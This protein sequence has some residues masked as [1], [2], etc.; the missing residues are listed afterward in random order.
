MDIFYL[1]DSISLFGKFIKPRK[2][3][4]S[5]MTST[6]RY[7]L[8]VFVFLVAVE[9]HSDST[10]VDSIPIDPS[11]RF[12][13]HA[14][15]SYF[16]R[17]LDVFG[18]IDEFQGAKPETAE[19]GRLGFMY[20]HPEH[21]RVQYEHT[22]SQG[23]V[24]KPTQPKKLATTAGSHHVRL[25][26]PI[27]DLGAW[28]TEVNVSLG[29]T[30]QKKTK[31]DC[32]TRGQLTLGGQ[33][34]EANFRLFDVEIFEGTGEVLPI[35]VLSV[36]GRQRKV[37]LS[38]SASRAFSGWLVISELSLSHSQVSVRSVSALFDID[39][40][41]IL[42]SSFSGQRVG[43]V[44]DDLRAELPQDHPW[45][46]TVMGAQ[47]KVVKPITD[48]LLTIAGIKAV[49]ARRSRY[50]ENPNVNEITDNFSLDLSLW[51]QLGRQSR[52][53]FR[54]EA[55]SN[56]LTGIESIAYNRKSSKFFRYPYGQLSVGFVY[57]F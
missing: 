9:S 16:D 7:F 45:R 2:S 3:S 19:L 29:Y 17:S 47:I 43:D 54:V 21:Y 12:L 6:I 53:Y 40:P 41:L 4:F 1:I 33:C 49:K 10:L 23:E 44:I 52:A 56:Y 26:I 48:K 14:E 39:E 31:I 30:S 50:L 46:E 18:F 42:D 55:F 25:H 28:S 51:Y 15:Y 34:E 35:P 20:V 8:G 13:V 57:S 38:Y 22:Y 37:G 32:Y 5:I 11:A 24:V 36:Q 27:G